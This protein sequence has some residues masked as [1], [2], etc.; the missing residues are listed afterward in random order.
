MKGKGKWSLVVWNVTW[1]TKCDGSWS[2][3]SSS[4][5]FQIFM[6]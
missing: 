3:H 5:R 1:H 6:Q 4:A 2:D